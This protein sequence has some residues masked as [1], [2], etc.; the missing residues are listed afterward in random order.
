MEFRLEHTPISPEKKI[1][2][3]DKIL[4]IGSCFTEHMHAQLNQYKF[5]AVQNPNGTLFNPI[6]I[7][8]AIESYIGL[9]MPIDNDLFFQNGLWNN[10][11]FH[12]SHSHEVKSDALSGM[13]GQIQLAHEVL[14]N[15]DWLFI[16][17]GSA[18]VYQKEDQEI[19]ANCHKLPAT[20][21][22]KR[23]LE[24]IEII[25]GFRSLFDHLQIFNK[26]IKVIFTISPVRHLRDGFVENNRSKAVLIHA[27]DK[28]SQEIP[29]CFYFPAYELIIDDLRDYRFFAEDMVHPNYLATKYV[30]E[31]FAT[32]YI[33]GKT[34]EVMKEIEQLNTAMIHKPMHPNS[35]EHQKFITKFRNITID[36][37]NRFPELDF[38]KELTHF[39]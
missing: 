16:T 13:I 32:S 31:K 23:L 33:D 17:L 35:T 6:S 30:W 4:L 5:S 1:D 36:L 20:H 34:R 21:F 25:R 27:V 18:F 26:D 22:S 38:S 15:A 10:W 19:V 2:I 28:I 8:K 12:S 11:H 7:F 37:S 14:K 39:N 29:D 3:N 9:D 24:P